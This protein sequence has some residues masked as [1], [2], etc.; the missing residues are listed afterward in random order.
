MK[1]PIMINEDSSGDPG[2]IPQRAYAPGEILGDIVDAYESTHRSDFDI[3][4]HFEDLSEDEM[5]AVI[6]MEVV[7]YE[8]WLMEGY[9][10]TVSDKEEANDDGDD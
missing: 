2:D 5:K 1:L 6:R 7:A 3:F 8:S 4:I 10:E 9:E